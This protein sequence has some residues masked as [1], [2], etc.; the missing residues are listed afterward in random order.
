MGA[1]TSAQQMPPEQPNF[2]GNMFGINNQPTPA[3]T[4]DMGNWG[5]TNA[6]GSPFDFTMSTTGGPMQNSPNQQT[7]PGGNPNACPTCG[8]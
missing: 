7:R 4:L 8:R 5:P 2:G 1:N 6:T 3:P